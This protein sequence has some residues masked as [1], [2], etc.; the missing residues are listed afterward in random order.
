VGKSGTWTDFS[1]TISVASCQCHSTNA[2]YT[3]TRASPTLYKVYQPTASS[4]HKYT[5]TIRCISSK[6][7]FGKERESKSVFNRAKNTRKKNLEATRK[8]NTKT[9]SQLHRPLFHTIYLL[10]SQPSNFVCSLLSKWFRFKKKS[11]HSIG[12]KIH[13]ARPS[14]VYVIILRF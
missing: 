14:F 12:K 4:K 7:S 13:L 11:L 1:S 9:S 6:Q 10:N 2:P 8:V 5:P 3:F